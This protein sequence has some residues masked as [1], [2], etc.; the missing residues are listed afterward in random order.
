MSQVRDQSDRRGLGPTNRGMPSPEERSLCLSPSGAKEPSCRSHSGNGLAG[1]T[2]LQPSQPSAKL[3]SWKLKRRLRLLA[4]GER[5]G[6]R[7]F[8]FCLLHPLQQCL[9]PPTRPTQA[10]GTSP[11]SNA[12]AETS[13]RLGF[14]L[15]PLSKAL[16]GAADRA[17]AGS[18]GRERQK[19]PAAVLKRTA[20]LDSWQGE[21]GRSKPPK[22]RCHGSARPTLSEEDLSEEAWGGGLKGTEQHPLIQER[23]SPVCRINFQPTQSEGN[24]IRQNSQASQGRKWDAHQQPGQKSLLELEALKRLQWAQP[25]PWL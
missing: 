8:P 13:R 14:L 24:V 4:H 20:P 19:D 23:T 1:S 25:L 7:S 2:A 22:R 21:P 12:A 5:G 16:Q 6:L 18:P 9:I 10:E 17:L 3:C 15:S 11:S